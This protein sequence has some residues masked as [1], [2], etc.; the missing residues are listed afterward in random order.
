MERKIA[1]KNTI[2]PE[3][4]VYIFISIYRSIP[5]RNEGYYLNRLLQNTFEEAISFNM[6]HFIGWGKYDAIDAVLGSNP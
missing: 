4:H 5:P 1:G 2:F 6:F 3:H